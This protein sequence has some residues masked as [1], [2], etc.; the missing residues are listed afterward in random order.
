M[1]WETDRL[2]LLSPKLTR[3]SHPAEPREEG[4]ALV[5]I[6]TI[7]FSLLSWKHPRASIRPEAFL[8]LFRR[9]VEA[10]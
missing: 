10:R 9:S 3:L 1:S 7:S 8:L 2:S 5:T 4:L 6:R